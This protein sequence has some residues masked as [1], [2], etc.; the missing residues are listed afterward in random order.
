VRV[1]GEILRRE[2]FFGFGEGVV[3]EQDGAED[4]F[5]GGD[6]GREACVESEAGGG[7]HD[8]QF[9]KNGPVEDCVETV[10]NGV[11]VCARL[12][13]NKCAHPGRNRNPA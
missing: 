8:I 2:L 4:H 13:T 3:L 6:V 1:E 5:F 11:P 10:Y 7:S 12:T 9:T